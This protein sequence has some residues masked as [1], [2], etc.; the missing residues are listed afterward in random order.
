MTKSRKK[1]P[2]ACSDCFEL[3]WA[4][5]E[6]H[7]SRGER[8]LREHERKEIIYRLAIATHR[9]RQCWL[10]KRREVEMHY[11]KLLFTEEMDNHLE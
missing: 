9:Q 11:G 1:N 5:W 8:Y 7:G 4:F 2:P 10:R 3:A 6:F